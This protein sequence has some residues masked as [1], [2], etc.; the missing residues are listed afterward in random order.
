M[1]CVVV[2]ADQALEMWEVS[3]EWRGVDADKW[4]DVV[5]RVVD[6]YNSKHLEEWEVLGQIAYE[7]EKA[8]AEK[9]ARI[10]FLEKALSQAAVGS[11]IV[12]CPE[13]GGKV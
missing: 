11:H 5:R 6:I 7:F 12:A 3:N 13:L 2:V 1:P 8:V 4:R 10:E 9:D